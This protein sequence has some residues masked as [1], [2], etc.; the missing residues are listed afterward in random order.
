MAGV[1]TLELV[2][3]GAGS[4]YYTLRFQRLRSRPLPRLNAS[5]AATLQ[6]TGKVKYRQFLQTPALDAVVR[7]RTGTAQVNPHLRRTVRA[8]VLAPTHRPFRTCAGSATANTSPLSLAKAAERAR[9]RQ[10]T[11]DR[12]EAS[13]SGSSRC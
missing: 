6:E 10:G 7:A 9:P 1:I 3:P 12:R 4:S 8:L 5:A 13:V 2:K 11:I